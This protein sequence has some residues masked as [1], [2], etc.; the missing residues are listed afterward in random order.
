MLIP[1]IVLVGITSLKQYV[2]ERVLFRRFLLRLFHT[3][4]LII[5]AAIEGRVGASDRR[6]VTLL[7][8]TSMLA[9]H[10][11]GIKDGRLGGDAGD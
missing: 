7:I 8:F 4:V 1:Q 6:R 10:L 9:T 5:D 3:L 11:E 2:R